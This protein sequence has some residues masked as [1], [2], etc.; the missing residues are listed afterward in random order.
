MTSNT[1]T[2]WL[3]GGLKV[4]DKKGGFVKCTN[5][6]GTCSRT[7]VAPSTV[8]K[9]EAMRWNSSI[10]LKEYKQRIAEKIELFDRFVE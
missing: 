7:H 5:P 6:K 9:A 2:H 4:E 8:T 10:S 3:A 1:C